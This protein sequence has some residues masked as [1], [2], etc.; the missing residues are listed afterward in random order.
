[1]YSTSLQVV[2]T[3]SHARAPL[4][5]TPFSAGLD[6]YASEHSTIQP[7]TRQLVDTGLVL[8]IPEG[9]YGRIAPR[10]GMSVQGIDVGAGVLDR[11]NVLPVGP[12]KIQRGHLWWM[13]GTELHSSSSRNTMS[14]RCKLSSRCRLL[15][16]ES[17]G[18]GRRVTDLINHNTD[19]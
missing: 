10:S 7:G 13:S 2:L 1:M 15:G 8:G 14:V 5:A 4:R 17:R 11:Q 9:C 16:G 19:Y 18:L 12:Q 6:L 3:S